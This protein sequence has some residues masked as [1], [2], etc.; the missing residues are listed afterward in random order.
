M[1]LRSSDEGNDGRPQSNYNADKTD[2][3]D[4]PSKRSL[5]NSSHRKPKLV[6]R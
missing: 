6:S 4:F 3:D 5:K 1:L 2:E